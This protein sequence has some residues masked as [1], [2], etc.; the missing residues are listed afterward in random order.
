MKK[1]LHVS[2]VTGIHGMEKH[3][4]DLLPAL[5]E[6]YSLRFLIL[7]EQKKPVDTYI[8][9]LQDE[10]IRVE[11][12][13]IGC[14]LDPAC[15]MRVFRCIKAFGPDL[16]HTHL[17]HGDLYGI[18]AAWLAGVP[19]IVST[20]HNDDAFRRRPII[21]TVNRMLNR[22]TGAVVAISDWVCRFAQQVEG[23]DPD[24]VV[25]IHY[26]LAD[27]RTTPDGRKLRADLGYGD[28]EIV[29]GIIARLTEQKGHRYLIDAFAE[30]YR[31]NCDVRLLIVGDGE[32][33]SEL[34]GR[35]RQSGV[36]EAVLFTGYRP[37]VSELLQALD[38]F[39]HPSLWEGF[40]LSILEAMDAAK[41]I[42]A[43]RVSAIPELIEDT[44]SGV[45]VPP[46][47][48]STL[49]KAMDAVAADG[50]LRQRLGDTARLRRE[51]LFSLERMAAQTKR[52]YLDLLK[53]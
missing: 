33:M 42:I 31:K 24:K 20:K 14:D 50:E 21:Q 5:A 16:V 38:V 27:T 19:C 22:K 23:V 1:I 52:V 7:T 9:L 12:V 13:S 26:G 2:K 32:L 10:G 34:K 4:L 30:V 53:D 25:T 46:K 35:V 47:D 43:T 18:T 17:I 15:L 3:L 36:E 11:P 28:T 41:P 40:G 39:V 29:F 48:V 49:A 51:E 44:Q 37:D 8:R 45:L 6:D